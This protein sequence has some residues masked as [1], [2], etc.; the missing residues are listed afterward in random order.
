VTLKDAA[1]LVLGSCPKK[2]FAQLQNALEGDYS[3]ATE[4]ATGER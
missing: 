2:T 1:R 3:P 4:V